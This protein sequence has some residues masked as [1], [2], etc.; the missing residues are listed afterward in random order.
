MFSNY[1]KLLDATTKGIIAWWSG[2]E[3]ISG[4]DVY[5][6]WAGV[7]IVSGIVVVSSFAFLRGK[8]EE[9]RLARRHDNRL[10]E[11]HDL[12]VQAKKQSIKTQSTPLDDAHKNP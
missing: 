9:W 7:F 12:E 11:L 5:L 2:K 8:F 6:Q 4:G 3:L 1:E 10:Q